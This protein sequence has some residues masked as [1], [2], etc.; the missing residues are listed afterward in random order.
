MNSGL[1]ILDA[2]VMPRSW[3]KPIIGYEVKT[4]KLDFIRDKKW[5]NYLAYCHEFY[6]ACPAGLIEHVY[7]EA[8]LIYIYPKTGYSRI[9][10]PAPFLRGNIPSTIFEY[11]LMWRTQGFK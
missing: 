10:K 8:G 4:Q 2:W 5:K 9:Q 6:F 11:V 1:Y 7:D 3:T